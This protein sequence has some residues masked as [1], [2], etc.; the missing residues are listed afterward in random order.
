MES[1]IKQLYKLSLQLMRELR[2]EL[3]IGESPAYRWCLKTLAWIRPSRLWFNKRTES[4]MELWNSLML[5]RLWEEK[6]NLQRWPRRS[7]II[8]INLIHFPYTLGINSSFQYH[9]HFIP[10]QHPNSSDGKATLQNPQY[11]NCMSKGHLEK[12]ILS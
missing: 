1:L 5:R 4:R 6:I 8:N 10:S 11:A 12:V 7:Y 3:V 2:T 9:S